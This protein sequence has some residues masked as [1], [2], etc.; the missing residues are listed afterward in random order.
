MAALAAG[1]VEALA[2]EQVVAEQV[3]P[4]AL[5]KPEVRVALEEPV[6]RVEQAAPEAKADGGT[7]GTAGGT[8]GG[9]G[10]DRN[11]N[12]HYAYAYEQSV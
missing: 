8:R 5:A 12:N 2:A 6:E 4:E 10:G 3:E 7:T 11:P 9:G 1:D